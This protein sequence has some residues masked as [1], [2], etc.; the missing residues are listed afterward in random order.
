MEQTKNLEGN[1]ENETKAK[2][3]LSFL[4]TFLSEVENSKDQFLRSNDHLVNLNRVSWLPDNS[5]LRMALDEG[6]YNI[7]Y[8]NGPSQHE[9][10]VALVDMM[11]KNIEYLNPSDREKADQILLKLKLYISAIIN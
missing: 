10:A 8:E 6:K 2:K 3:I 5:E 4:D 9:V 11:N 1:N 7:D